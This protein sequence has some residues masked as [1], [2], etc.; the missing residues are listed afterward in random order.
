MPITDLLKRNA[1]LAPDEIALVEI[2]P[3]TVGKAYSMNIAETRAG[4]KILA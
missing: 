1:T 3:G 4:G 2:N